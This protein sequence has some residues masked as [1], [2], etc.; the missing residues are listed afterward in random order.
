MKN[1]KSKIILFL[2]A[3]CAVSSPTVNAQ[4]GAGFESG[5][6]N[7]RPYAEVGIAYDDN[8]Y[9]SGA[10]EVDDFYFDPKV[11]LLFTTSPDAT[12]L[13]LSGGGYFNRR[14]YMDE[15]KSSDSYG[16][17][18]SLDLGLG[19]NTTAQAVGGYRLLEE[20]DVLGPVTQLKGVN[21]GLIQDIDASAIERE[22][23]DVGAIVE[24][25]FSERTSGSVGSIYSFVDYDNP[26]S[27]DLSGMIGQFSVDHKLT[28]KLGVFGLGRAGSQEQDG[29]NQTADSLAGQAGVSLTPTDKL[30][31]RAGLGAESYT[32]SIPGQADKDSDNIS[33]SLILDLQAT[34][35]LTLSAGGYN[36]T[37]LSSTFTD[38]AVDFINSFIGARLEVSDKFDLN[39]RA[40]YRQDDYVDAIT[41][42]DIT[43]E[44]TD[45][46]IQFVLRVNYRP[47]LDYLKV[48]AQIS[49]EDVNSTVDSIDYVRNLV[50]AG[51]SVAY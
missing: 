33:Y 26:A 48:F 1:R 30:K 16:G 31:L 34:D 22:V 46:R 11:G 17:G 32:R 3:L 38:N 44:R 4:G 39:L 6:W 42:D 13:K 36:G 14:E 25:N 2:V 41:R 12:T 51:V 19:D 23:V 7:L 20:E 29:D 50:L 28:D 5:S 43:V 18:L 21:Q 8:V 9:R 24:H 45:D 15:D 49:T 37:Q 10:N 40:V 47:P 27:L 35:K